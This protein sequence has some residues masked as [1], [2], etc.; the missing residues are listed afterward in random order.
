MSIFNGKSPRSDMLTCLGVSWG[1]SI[2]FGVMTGGS[3]SE[4]IGWIAII[5]LIVILTI[6]AVV[7]IR[8]LNDLQRS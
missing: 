7:S 2:F 4:A 8:R 3:K 6:L 1:I 5:L